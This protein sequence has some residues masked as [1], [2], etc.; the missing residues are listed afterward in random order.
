MLLKWANKKFGYI[1]FTVVHN[2]YWENASTSLS[3]HTH[4]VRDNIQM[5]SGK[6]IHC[7]LSFN[8]D[9]KKTMWLLGSKTAREQRTVLSVH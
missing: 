5:S 2:L 3:P 9:Y 7:P 4:F 8:A 6:T 1:R